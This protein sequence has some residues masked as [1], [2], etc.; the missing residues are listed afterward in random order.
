MLPLKF[1]PN[2]EYELIRL[3]GENDGGYVVEKNSVIDSKSLLTLG[4]GYEWRFEKEYFKLNHNSITCFDHSVNYSSIKK[5]SRKYLAS[6]LFRILKPKYFIKKNFFKNL[7]RNIFLFMDYKN[8]FINNVIHVEKRVGNGQKEICLED[9]L[10]HKNLIFPCF[11]KVD[12]EGSEYRIL[13]EIINFKSRFTGMVI[14][15]HDVDLHINRILNFID[16][17]DFDVVHIHPQNP[18]PVTKN[19]IPTQIELSFSKNPTKIGDNPVLPHQLDMPANPDFEEI[20]M[21]FE[22]K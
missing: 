20:A 3:G 2:F 6:Y 21:E 16:K 8:F 13:D 19:N 1:K 11:L 18:A 12:I 10:K 15:F 4:L 9:I 7:V 17:L 22:K 5:L 14:E